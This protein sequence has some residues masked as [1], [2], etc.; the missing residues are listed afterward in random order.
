MLEATAAGLPLIATRVGGIPEIFG[1]D[2]GELVPSGDPAALAQAIASAVRDPARVRA[3]MQ[4]LQDRVRKQ[5]SADAMVDAVLKAY[6]QA[7]AKGPRELPVT[8]QSDALATR[9][10]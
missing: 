8:R 2:A 6:G 3:T 5:F 10:G 1:P 9:H 4:R 7:L